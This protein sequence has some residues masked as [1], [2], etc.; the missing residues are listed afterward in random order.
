M[1]TDKQLEI[2][3]KAFESGNTDELVKVLHIMLETIKHSITARKYA[4][5]I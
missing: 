1:N 3:G 4:I 2:L 5:K